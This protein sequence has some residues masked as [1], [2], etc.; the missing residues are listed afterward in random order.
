[1]EKQTQDL[2]DQL[3]GQLKGK[4]DFE[5]L[6]EALFKRG[7]EKLLQAELS[8]HLGY[9]KRSKIEGVPTEVSN[10]RNGY[11]E[12]TLKTSQGDQC[13][14]VPRDRAGTFEPIIVPKHKTI[15]TELEDCIQL[16]YAKGMSNADIIDFVEQTYGVK[17]S[18]SQVSLITNTLLAD[19]R[20]WQYRPLQDQYAV[21]W[22]D[23]IHYKIR[24]DGKVISK[25][26]MLVL[27]IDMEGKQD[28]LS[29]FIVEQE[30]ASAWSGILDDLKTRGVKDILFLC[31]D[32]LTGITKAAGAIFPNSIH[33]ICIV[34]QVRNSLKF[35]AHKDRKAV[36]ADMKKIYKADNEAMAKQAFEQFKTNWN[37]KYP[38]AVKSWENNWEHL[39]AFLAFPAEI[40]KLIY[41]TNIIESFN[42]CLRK[43]TKNKRVFPTDDA[44]LKSIFLAAQQI[45]KKWQKARFGWTQ[46][47]N[48]LAIYFEGRIL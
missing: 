36:V 46:V 27:G 19:I 7:V 44:A 9:E 4:E 43:F 21:I 22:F 11:S 20:E 13:I 23:A 35:V 39:T 41:T 14:R 18:T 48:Q 33:Q 40:R 6:R 8:A 31:S 37:D 25:A 29:I 42:S 34:H 45:R 3:V 1:M 28:L 24:Q 30:S 5:V 26:A 47:Y 16:L 12:K 17:Y 38:I 10:I 15:S 32:N 2:L